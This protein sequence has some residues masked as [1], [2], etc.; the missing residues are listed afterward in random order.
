MLTQWKSKKINSKSRWPMNKVNKYLEDGLNGRLSESDL[1]ALKE[2]LILMEVE[3]KSKDLADDI[4]V[5]LLLLKF[6]A[7]LINWM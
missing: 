5:T 1:A 4:K 3:K 6:N 7:P 2:E